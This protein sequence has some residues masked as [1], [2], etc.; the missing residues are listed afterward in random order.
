M[1]DNT[2]LVKLDS[3]AYVGLALHQNGVQ[4]IRSVVLEN[5]GVEHLRDLRVEIKS[6]PE[7]FTPVEL[8][9]SEIAAGGAVQLKDFNVVPSH[10]F[11]AS[12]TERVRGSIIVDVLA[13]GAEAPLKRL[14]QNIDIC[15][16]DEWF[17]G[18][19][20]PEM[21]AAFVTPNSDGVSTLLK[22]SSELMQERSGNGAL[23]GYQSG[24]K[25]RVLLMVK[26]IY[27]A[28]LES[29][30][31]Y[32]EAPASFGEK[33]QRVRFPD[34]ILSTKFAACLDFSLLFAGMMEQC[35]LHPLVMLSRGHAYVACHLLRYNFPDSVVDDLQSIRKRAEIDEIVAFEST[36]AAGGRSKFSVAMTEGA[37]RLA[38][39]IDF[40]YALDVKQA[41]A[42]GVRPLS[43]VAG[44][45]ELS[46]ATADPKVESDEALPEL[47]ES[48]GSTEQLAESKVPARVVR[49]RSK[50][51]DLSRRNRLLNF[52]DSKQAIQV[53]Y[54][55][56]KAI[57]DAVCNGVEFYIHP[58]PDVFSDPK[59][60][61]R[62]LTMLELSRGENPVAKYMQDEFERR[63]LRTFL[64][65]KELLKR[66]T[67]LYRTC[68]TDIEEGGVNTLFLAIGFL[69]WTD[70]SGASAQ[71][72]RAPLVLV[73]VRLDRETARTGYTLSQSEDDSVVNVTLL[74]ML[75][76]DFGRDIAG[77][78]PPPQDEHGIDVAAVLRIFRDAVVNVKGWQV[79]E[80]VW[81]GRLFFNKFIMWDDMNRRIDD[82]SKNPV[83]GHLIKGGGASFDDG[84]EPVAPSNVDTCIKAEELL[85]PM[86]ADSSQLAAV[87]SAARGKNFVLHGPPGTGKSQTIT[88]LISYCLAVGKTVLFV[89]EKRAALEV[90]QRRLSRIGLAPFCLELHSN[91][92]GKAGVLRQFAEAMA[93]GDKKEPAA[94]AEAAKDLVTSRSSLSGYV[95]ELHKEYPCGL[96]PYKAFSYLFAHESEQ[97]LMQAVGPFRRIRLERGEIE[98]MLDAGR[99]LAAQAGEI[100]PKIFDKFSFA[101]PMEWS[102]TWEQSAVNA[103]NA[104]GSETVA[105]SQMLEVFCAIIDYPRP[106]SAAPTSFDEFARLA[107]LMQSL[108]QLPESFFKSDWENFRAELS[109][110]SAA[111]KVCRDIEKKLEGF[112]MD[113]VATFDVSEMRTRLKDNA[114]R[115]V[116]TRM[117]RGARARKDVAVCLKPGSRRKVSRD[118]IPQ[119][120]EDFEVYASNRKAVESAPDAITSRIE[121][122]FKGLETDWD[123]VDMRSSVCQT[124]SESLRKIADGNNDAYKTMCD[125]VGAHASAAERAFTPEDM[126]AFNVAHT[127]FNEALRVFK[128]ALHVDDSAIKN[129]GVVTAAAAMT[130]AV[131]NETRHLRRWCIWNQ[132]RTRSLE[133]GLDP[134]VAAVDAGELALENIPLTIRK[135]YCERFVDDVID[136]SEVIRNFIGG[137][138]DGLV[139]KFSHID[140]EIEKLAQQTTVARLAS[141]LPSGRLGACPATSEL[142]MLK[143][144]CEKK[145]RHKPVRTLLEMIPTILPVLKPCMLMSPLSVAQYLPPGSN[146]FDIIVFDEASQI[147]VW[148]AIGAMARGRQVIIVGDPK[149]LPPTTFFQ[150]TA[151]SEDIDESDIEELESILDECKTAGVSDMYLQWHYRS[152]H[153]S[154]IAFSNQNYYN[155]S[156]MTFPSSVRESKSLGVSFNLVKD[157]VYDK[158][159]TRTNRL[160]AEALV[161]AVVARL[162]DPE[163]AK[164]STGIVTFSVAQQSIIED[165]MDEKRAEFPEIEKFFSEDNEEPFFVKNLESVQGDERD[166]IFFSICYGFDT[167][168]KFAMNFGPLNRPGGERR[169]NVA[170]TRAKEQVV[171]FSS[172]TSLQIDTGRTQATGAVHLKNFLE[173]AER[174]NSQVVTTTAAGADSGERLFENEVAEFLRVHGYKVD[175]RVGCSG[176]TIDIAVK[177]PDDEGRYVIGIECD[178]V[179]YG[180]ANS[181]RDRDKLRA[182]VLGGLGWRLARV[183]STSWWFDRK[184]AESKLLAEVDAAVRGQPS[185]SVGSA[186]FKPYDSAPKTE[187]EPAFA[188]EIPNDR[189]KTYVPAE[190]VTG[191]S[192]SQSNFNLDFGPQ[193]IGEQMRRIV[194]EEGPITESLLNKRVIIEWGFSRIG[195]AMAVVL[196]KS[197][198]KAIKTTKQFGERVFWPEGMDSQSYRYYRVPGGSDESR[199]SIKEIPLVEIS[200]AMACIRERFQSLPEEAL[201]SE[202]AKIFGFPRVTSTLEKYLDEAAKQSSK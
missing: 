65:E 74:E 114:E 1:M 170:V 97:D 72:Y 134:V 108:P 25:T 117:I 132:A 126:K 84:I 194:N 43:G 148:D 73:P 155:N 123:A 167:N 168:G 158:S 157:G 56:L 32:M 127:K 173:Y 121:G 85:C 186:K 62:N 21:L 92:A 171:V 40:Y 119:L 34:K 153:E 26:C 106:S 104:L 197:V 53:A 42:I 181:A 99:E 10:S 192:K 152:R 30:V 100:E 154:L 177:A 184:Q 82:L 20:M 141:R 47:S 176:Y 156:L 115:F 131:L 29:G 169:L 178:G 37:K 160:E 137:A 103:A 89:A 175:T 87:I 124:L 189:E 9:V 146:D 51:L 71:T 98:A 6:D 33:G 147:T 13:S 120:M 46:G 165:L 83:V 145:T 142:G 49:W 199:R 50:L 164:K 86:S 149:Q 77:L 109:A 200:N 198:P 64:E 11:F 166:A 172:V 195:S 36:S 151:E 140:D 23:D 70:G 107:L 66:L 48:I 55:N 41:R 201:Y 133:K 4:F 182:I 14:A 105:I 190:I 68:R 60:D 161:D 39:D 69:K 143:R 113:A 2:L 78:N 95:S 52:K 125:A 31:N 59:N 122:L 138:H 91:K 58:R 5:K 17:G 185:P 193:I 27:D 159:K 19:F 102:P 76:R 116:L 80:D 57:E 163:L 28:V 18:D 110:V 136:K 3:L 139:E 35:G 129:R 174:G 128:T 88:N 112:N 15:A 162:R 111:G 196:E 94:W 22:R 96:T 179:M 191:Y 183:W 90:V 7:F 188:V 79:E 75:K 38:E 54:Y 81:I 202:T 24:D 45:G 135:R 101:R 130:E 63:R 187:F 12:V 8:A 93:F 144:E 16:H 150:R 180:S 61:P 67:E 118:E 44:L